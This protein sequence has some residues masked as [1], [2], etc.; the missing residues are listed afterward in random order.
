MKPLKV[1]VKK[2]ALNLD[3]LTVQWSDIHFAHLFINP[4]TAEEIIDVLKEYLNER[5]TD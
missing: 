2:S 3:F 4:E 5:D 1:F